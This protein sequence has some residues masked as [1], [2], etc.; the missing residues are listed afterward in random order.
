MNLSG[1]FTVKRSRPEVYRFL[2]DPEC[3]GRILPDLESLVIQGPSS[4]EA[5]VRVGISFIKGPLRVRFDLIE[6]REG[7]RARYNGKG[8][9]IGSFVEL[10]V[11]F[12]LKD[13]GDHETEI[14]WEG[15]ATT[16]GRIAT[17]ASGLLLQVAKK[18]ANVF[19][20]ALKKEMEKCA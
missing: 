6:A 12:F 19:I 14:N 9:G 13:K 16:G 8:A 17:V 18:N 5:V 2:T 11:E 10:Q 1:E 15:V 7:E 3:F 4:F 20:E